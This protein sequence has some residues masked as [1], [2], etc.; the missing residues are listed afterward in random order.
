MDSAPLEFAVVNVTIGKLTVIDGLVLGVLA[1]FEMSVAV[2]VWLPPVLRLIEKLF[3]PETNAASGGKVAPLSEE[4]IRTVSV[5][6]LIRFQLA[7]TALT[8]TTKELPASWTVGVP[9][10]PDAVPGAAVSPGTNSCS[11]VNE[12]ELTVKL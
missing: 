12:P 9:V 10:L 6:V 3:V 7:S 11:L 5:T 4:V 1:P 2:S 8:V